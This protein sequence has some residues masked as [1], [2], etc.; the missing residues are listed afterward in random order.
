MNKKNIGA[1]VAGVALLGAAAA[2]V[3]MAGACGTSAFCDAGA[4]SST[5]KGTPSNIQPKAQT[6]RLAVEG[7]SCPMCAHDV[8][9]VLETV[10]GFLDG[11]VSLDR[12]E[13]VVRYDPARTNPRALAQAVEAKA[14][15][16]TSVE[17]AD[18]KGVEP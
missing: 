8:H 17:P 3:R 6:C 9:S 4:R 18:K 12:G 15:Y 1:M 5:G 7:M 14:G 2:M 16:K 10:P 11:D 13:A